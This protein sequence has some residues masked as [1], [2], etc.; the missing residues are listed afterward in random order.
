MT[1]VAG[2]SDPTNNGVDLAPR[3]PFTALVVTILFASIV[4]FFSPVAPAGADPPPE[5]K[6][7]SATV[8]PLAR[9]A[10][11]NAEMDRVD[12]EIKER[13]AETIALDTQVAEA[14]D[15][16][17][18]T[19]ARIATVRTEI[20]AIRQKIRDRAVAIYVGGDAKSDVLTVLA[21]TDLNDAQAVAIYL[22]V[23]TRGDDQLASDLHDTVAYLADLNDS[24]R[25]QRAFAVAQR[26]RLAEELDRLEAFRKDRAKAAAQLGTLIEEIAKAEADARARAEAEL[27]AKAEA[28]ARARAEA[29]AERV[30][31][32]TSAPA[33]DT[34]PT[35]SVG[36]VGI[37]TVEGTEVACSI[38][39]RFGDMVADA[40]VDGVD[41]SGGGGYRSPAGQVAVRRKNCGTSPAAIYEVPAD[42]CSPP[43]ARPGSSQHELGLAVDFKNCWT[44]STACHVWLAANADRY[45]LF[46]LDV[47]PWHWSESG[48]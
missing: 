24:V 26:D 4:T 44:R 43:T 40:R 8:D 34:A 21:G 3:R 22:D 13:R 18:A 42:A 35:P 5:D 17:E 45:G 46:P 33:T 12:T 25:T 10:A 29:E 16:A 38:A 37:C 30:P 28:D 32:T 1:L 6:S 7:P 31:A 27:R 39:K 23:E 19:T 36:T 41:L 14:T 2:P 15:R 9:L 20:Q 47:E 11:V 48:S